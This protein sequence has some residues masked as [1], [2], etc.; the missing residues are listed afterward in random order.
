M[1]LPD[2]FGY[3]SVFF[4]RF[5]EML[6]ETLISIPMRSY[7]SVTAVFLA[8]VWSYAPAAAAPYI[9]EALPNTE[10][11]AILEYFSVSNASCDPVSF[12]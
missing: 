2:Y 9:S 10:D 11:D 7:A 3:F 1:P 4:A 12:S 5:S 8:S 6:A